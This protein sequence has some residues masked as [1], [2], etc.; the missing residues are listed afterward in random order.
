MREFE[1]SLRSNTVESIFSI[2]RI[3]DAQSGTGYPIRLNTAKT[4]FTAYRPENTEPLAGP[5][6]STVF[7][8]YQYT[9]LNGVII[10]K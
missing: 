7:A 3:G 9:N 2:R 5:E 8:H 1:D 4:S 10:V 6:S